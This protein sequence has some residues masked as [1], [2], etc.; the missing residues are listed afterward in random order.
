MTFSIWLQKPKSNSPVKIL[1][2]AA[3]SIIAA[4]PEDFSNKRYVIV[5]E[6]SWTNAWTSKFFD[7][8]AFKSL[9]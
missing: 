5:E 6:A 9:E 8:K 3:G 4:T 7:A 1:K 2:S